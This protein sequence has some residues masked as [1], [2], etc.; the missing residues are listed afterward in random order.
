MITLKTPQQDK[1]FG[2]RLNPWDNRLN[3]KGEPFK[4]GD[5]YEPTGDE[6]SDRLR[7]GYIFD[8]YRNQKGH[9]ITKRSDGYFNARWENGKMLPT[10]YAAERWKPPE[11]ERW[12]KQAYHNKCRWADRNNIKNELTYLDYKKLFEAWKKDG[13][14]ICGVKNERNGVNRGAGTGKNDFTVDR[15]VP[16]KGYTVENTQQMCRDCNGK[17]GAATPELLGIK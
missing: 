15:I 7:E 14:I 10:G 11:S 13:C 3:S 4:R 6:E 5:I 2:K 1:R 9:Y 8:E 16:D 17:K 12:I